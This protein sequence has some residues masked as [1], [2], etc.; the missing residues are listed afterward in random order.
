MRSGVF[1]TWLWTPTEL[2]KPDLALPPPSEHNGIVCLRRGAL[3]PLGQAAGTHAA[4]RTVKARHPS[5]VCLAVGIG[6]AETA[7]D[8]S[9][10]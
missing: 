5:C 3:L 9:F 4:A 6:A 7:G 10:P 8:T 2:F 1:N